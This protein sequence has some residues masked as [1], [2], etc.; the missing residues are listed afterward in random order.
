MY[1]YKVGS[2]ITLLAVWIL[3]FDLISMLSE[4]F[5]KLIM[6]IPLGLLLWQ[7]IRWLCS[8][9]TL[10]TLQRA[11]L[12][13]HDLMTV[14]AWW[15]YQVMLNIP[16]FSSLSHLCWGVMRSMHASQV[17]CHPPQSEICKELEMSPLC[18]THAGEMVPPWL[19]PT[20][21]TC[22]QSSSSITYCTE[23][24]FVALI[25]QGTTRYHK[26]KTIINQ[27]MQTLHIN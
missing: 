24:V 3:C 7:R 15:M 27:S 26:P 16:V 13:W 12:N 11:L 22:I 2:F 1:A 14:M 18:F 5:F 25:K 23:K 21:S 10:L 4:H 17:S 20:P 9:S 8:P 19:W 6:D